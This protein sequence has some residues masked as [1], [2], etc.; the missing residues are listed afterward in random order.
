MIHTHIHR[1]G[2]WRGAR[3]FAATTTLVASLLA[4][5][6]GPAAHAQDGGQ[7]LDLASVLAHVRENDPTIAAARLRWEALRERAPAARALPD[8]SLTLGYFFANVETRVGPMK[9]RLGLSQKI[10]F[11][12]KLKLAE[13]RAISE[14]ETAY[15]TYLRLMRERTTAAKRLYAE[16]YRVDATRALVTQQT[17][18]VEERIDVLSRQYE[19]AQAELP[20]LLLANQRLAEMRNRLHALDGQRAGAG[21]QINRLMATAPDREIP[22]V[23]DLPEVSLPDYE[24]LIGLAEENSEWLQAETSAIATAEAALAI[25]EKERMPDFTVG[26]QYTDIGD[27]SFSSP[28][29][30]GQ[31][32][33][34]GFVSINLPIWRGKYRAL[35]EAAQIQLEAAHTRRV[36]TL[37]DLQA[38]ITRHYARATAYADQI[39]LYRNELLP[40][41]E[42]RHEA[43]LSS[44]G[45]GR[46]TA[47]HWIESQRDLLQAQTGL[48]LLEAEY[49]AAI[50]EVEELAAAELIAP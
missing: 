50:A 47:L 43:T 29:D 21:A 2:H 19:S 39:A 42:A 4:S 17:S 16:L 7:Q 32:A 8:P 22:T 11:P 46:T 25:A 48:A 20:D 3:R 14:A 31:D 49:F 5:L 45:A 15:W 24:R 33:A 28:P 9:G 6:A 38:A 1:A 40:Q 37:Q 18:L 10:P 30:D 23:A 27:N 35:E 13:Q 36:A 34:M 12:G 44:Y 41:A 26:V